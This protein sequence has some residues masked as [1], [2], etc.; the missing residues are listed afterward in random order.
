MQNEVKEVIA[1]AIKFAEES[2]F[3]TEKDLYDSVYEQSDYPF[4]K[5]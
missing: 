5:N 4:I 2:P 1:E 3:P